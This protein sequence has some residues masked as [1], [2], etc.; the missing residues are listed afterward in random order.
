MSCPKSTRPARNII[1][2]DSQITLQAPLS[3][4]RLRNI[5]SENPATLGHESLCAPCVFT[6]S[7]FEECWLSQNHHFKRPGVSPKWPT[8]SAMP[9]LSLSASRFRASFQRDSLNQCNLEPVELSLE[10]PRVGG[11]QLTVSSCFF[12]SCLSMEMGQPNIL[13]RKCYKVIEVHCW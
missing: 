11:G 8:L 10:L 12:V 2:P 13:G 1:L 9:L 4:Q 3:C 6:D 7:L 5:K